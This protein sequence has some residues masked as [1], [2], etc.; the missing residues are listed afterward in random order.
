MI[1]RRKNNE[2]IPKKSISMIISCLKSKEIGIEG[3]LVS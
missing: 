2:S 3:G 1:V